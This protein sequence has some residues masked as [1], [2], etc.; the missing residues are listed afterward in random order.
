MKAKFG[1]I[2]VDGRGKIGGHVASKNRYGSYWRTKVTPINRN[3]DAQKL[4]RNRFTTY[5]QGWKA[6][7][8]AQRA[9]WNNA[10]ND[11]VKTNIFGDGV[12]P[13][14]A[15]LYTRLNTNIVNAGATPI[16]SPPTDLKVLSTVINSVTLAAGAQTGTIAYTGST[17]VN[18]VM[19]VRATPALSAG[20]SYVSN[21]FKQVKT[22]AGNTATPTLFGPQWIAVYGAIPAAGSIVWVEI[23]FINNTTGLQSARQKFRCIVAV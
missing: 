1:S 11:F 19:V 14:G 5:S 4:V 8:D 9:A 12:K 3:T 20:K 6:L 23:Y 13:T 7:T 16:V 17:P 15:T 21:L 2:V 18:H 22:Q 10:V